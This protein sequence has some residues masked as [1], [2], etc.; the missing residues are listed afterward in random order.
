MIDA[1]REL[2]LS[3]ADAQAKLLRVYWAMGLVLFGILDFVA[4]PASSIFPIA[5]GEIPEAMGQIPLSM[6]PT[7]LVPTAS[8]LEI[9]D[10][11]NC[12]SCGA[13]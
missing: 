2:P 8:T 3:K 12:G 5:M 10:G 1:W 11:F 7:C 6:V 13:G 9:W 4:A